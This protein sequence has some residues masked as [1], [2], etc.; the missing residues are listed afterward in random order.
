MERM[1][2]SPTGIMAA[3]VTTARITPP[4]TIVALP[5]HAVTAQ[6][7]VPGTNITAAVMEAATTMAPATITAV[8]VDLSST[9]QNARSQMGLGRYRRNA[10]MQ[11]WAKILPAIMLCL[12]MALVFPV[13]ARADKGNDG[14][15]S[16][17]GSSSG[18]GGG[19]NAGFGSSGSDHSG[20][21]G[22]HG[23]DDSAGGGSHHGD[24]DG[25]TGSISR[26]DDR[27]YDG[28]WHERI[29][30]GRYELFDPDGRLVIRRAA[31]GSDIDRRD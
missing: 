18:S 24:D 17:S 25:R 28:G 10:H 16:G 6:T 5:R 11:G 13:A 31:K 4:T 3:A 7:M 12:L 30:N 15:S 9:D 21:S 23:S 1:T 19:S 26:S 8:A 14:G 20:S 27:A 22:S 2:I 29:R